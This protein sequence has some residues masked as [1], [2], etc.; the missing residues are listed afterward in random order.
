MKGPEIRQSFLDFFA[1]KQHDIVPSAPVVPHDDPGLMFTN[2]GMNQFKPYFLGQATPEHRRIADTQKCIRVSGKHNDLEEVGHDTY[3]HTFFEML[4]NWSFGD[5]YKREAISWAWELLTE[6]WGLPAE[7]LYATVFAGDEQVPCDD[8]AIELWKECTNID[9]SHILK[10]DRKD[11]FWMMGD[12]G[13]CGPCSEIHI[14]LTPDQSGGGLVNADSPQVIE[15]WNLV[16]IQYNAEEDGSLRELPAKHVDTGMGFERAC[17]VL[18][19]TG[20]GKDF[21]GEVSNYD[22]EVFQPLI[23]ELAKMS[24]RTYKPGLS[25]DEASIA[26][27]VCA[28]H[29]RMTAFAIADGAFPSNDGRGYVVRRL[30]RRAARYGRSK[31]GLEEPFLH[32][33]LPVLVKT[34]GDVFPELV[35]EKVKIGN[36]IRSEE[37]S[38]NQ[39]LDRGIALFEEQIEQLE[40]KVFSGEVAFK[41]YDTFGFPV[42]LTEAMARELGFS[43]DLETFEERMEEQRARAREAQVKH[44]VRAADADLNLPPTPFVGLMN[45][46]LTPRLRPF[47]VKGT[48]STW[49]WPLAP[50][51]P[52]WVDSWVIQVCSAGKASNSKWWIRSKPRA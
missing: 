46:S 15:L 7:R 10:F 38:F 25:E 31:L 13:P 24:G 11:N 39:T 5:Y 42:D 30:I 17:A 18:E 1:G 32:T 41:L 48:C 45:S 3:H 23:R 33:L 49:C 51:M 29:I 2:A 44:V 36:L 34:M 40:G 20:G 22:T 12:T 16:F 47:S 6:V 43:V 52:R 9:P 21:S 50:S 19:C 8:E 37:V 28:D 27:R 35:R 4:G 26:M 14:D